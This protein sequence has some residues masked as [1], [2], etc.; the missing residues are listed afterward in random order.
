M[1]NPIPIYEAKNKLP[2]FIHLSET[3]SKSVRKVK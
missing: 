1:C 2:Y 3:R